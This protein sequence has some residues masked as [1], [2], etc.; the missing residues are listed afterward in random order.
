M[1]TLDKRGQ[2]IDTLVIVGNPDREIARPAAT[3]RRVSHLL[4][5]F[6]RLGQDSE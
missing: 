2:I 3:P 5:G 4:R 6:P 1:R